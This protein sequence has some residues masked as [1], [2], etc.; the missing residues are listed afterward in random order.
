MNYQQTYRVKVP[1]DIRPG[2]SFAVSIEGISNSINITCPEGQRPG[3]LIELKVYSNANHNVTSYDIGAVNPIQYDLYGLTWNHSKITL[4]WWIVLDALLF[5]LLTAAIL[6]PTFS[7]Q[8]ISSECSIPGNINPTPLYYSYWYGIGTDVS[9]STK[10]GNYCIGWT[11]KQAWHFI[12]LVTNAHME[13][14]SNYFVTSQV[15]T[16]Y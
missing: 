14:D 4:Y 6:V 1:Q 7:T 12:D 9:C 3:G 11:N 15:S 5:C 8:R 2:D 13:R 16:I 10:N